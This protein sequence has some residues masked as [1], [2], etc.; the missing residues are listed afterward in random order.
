MLTMRNNSQLGAF[1]MVADQRAAPRSARLWMDFLNQDT[2]VIVGTEQ[3]AKKFDYPVLFMNVIREKRGY[4]TCEFE[5]IEPDPLNSEKHAI[6]EKYMH[7][8]EDKIKK[9]P[10]FW[11]WTHNRWKHK[12]PVEQ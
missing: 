1:V 7:L 5:M 10:E 4:Y 11:L 12:R 6:T 3:L 2:A 9:H 8:L